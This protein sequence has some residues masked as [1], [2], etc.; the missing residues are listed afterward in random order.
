MKGVV[1]AGGLGTRLSPLTR[2]TN[3]HLLPVY[4][5]PMIYYPVETLVKSGIEDIM[6]VTGGNAAGDFLKLMGNGSEFG[7]KDLYYTYQRG[8]GG[9]AEALSLAEHF[10]SGDK[11][12]VVLGDNILED[13]LS[14]AVQKFEKQKRG[15][16]I[17]L[18]EVTDPQRFGVPVFK[19]GKIVNIEE[20]PKKPKSQYAVTGI[21]MYDSRVFEFCRKLKPSKRGELE[22]SD[23]NNCYIKDG[24]MQYDILKGYWTDAGTFDSLLHANKLAALK[25]ESS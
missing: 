10:V 16:R 22:I 11:V 15:A 14:E 25:A 5:K 17:F 8:E 4:D 21:Y 19:N 13:N 9:I 1:L 6:I 7:L 20:K 12:V 2:V 24:S 23:V 18:K 3:K